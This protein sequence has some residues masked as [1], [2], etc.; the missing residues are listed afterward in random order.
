MVASRAQLASSRAKR[1]G[2]RSG[3]PRRAQAVQ[4]LLP[5]TDLLPNRN[6]TFHGGR[7]AGAGRPRTG[8]AVGVAHRR[9]ADVK[10]GLPI[11]V[12]S[13]FVPEVGYLRTR[14]VYQVVR[15]SLA[16]ACRR[17]GFRVCHFSLQRNHLHLIVEAD[18]ST[19]LRK[20][21]T[22]L[23]V[24]LARGL[25]RLR[26]R[27]GQVF[28]DRY[29]HAVKRT[30]TDVR[31]ALRYV[32]LNARRHAHEV[33]DKHRLVP[34]YLD[35]FSSARHFDGWSSRGRRHLSP[36]EDDE[37]APIAKPRTWLLTEGWRKVGLL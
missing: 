1:R 27:T 13:R 3:S 36:P 12:T 31:N 8:R 4:G 16:A 28:P 24:R 23:L 32:L 15:R 6:G 18:S 22:G 10:R 35:P 37:D 2:G 34:G 14:K 7:R 21:M 20:G 26:R 19:L 30:P 5:H 33:H 17:R 9:R 29:H 11:H 25:N